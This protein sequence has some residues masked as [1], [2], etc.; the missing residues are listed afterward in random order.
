MYE[1]KLWII[2]ELGG[3]LLMDNPEKIGG[4]MKA[5]TLLILTALFGV[6]FGLAYLLI[7]KILLDF[8]GVDYSDAAV[9]TARFF[10][11]TVLGFGILAWSARNAEDSPT[12]KAI[13][14]AIFFTC[15]LGLVLSII[16]TVTGFFTAYGWIPIA[17]FVLIILAFVYVLLK[18]E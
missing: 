10:G 2:H 9:M 8:F 17:F 13:K 16:S 11:G 12:R 5:K 14:L 4:I 6:V 1:K 15:L 18:K 7:P 3:C